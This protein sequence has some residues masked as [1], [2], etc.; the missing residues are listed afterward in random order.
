ME[1]RELKNKI[2]YFVCCVSEFAKVHT[3]SHR[4]AY[5]YLRRF[6]GIEFLLKHYEAEHTLSIDEAVGD[7]TMICQRHGGALR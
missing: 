4:Q 1:S 5:A 7:L 6:C 3:L 2:D